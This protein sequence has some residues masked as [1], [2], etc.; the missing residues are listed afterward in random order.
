MLIYIVCVQVKEQHTLSNT[1]SAGISYG[2]SGTSATYFDNNEGNIS[3]FEELTK[4]INFGFRM[5]LR[6]QNTEHAVWHPVTTMN[7]LSPPGLPRGKSS[8]SQK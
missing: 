2:G 4:G 3:Y 1:M 7:L 8:S 6:P 5:L